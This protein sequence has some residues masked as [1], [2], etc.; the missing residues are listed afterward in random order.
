MADVAIILGG[1]ESV[2]DE[3]TA[4]VHM[5]CDA[6]LTFENFC[7]N[8][9]IGAFRLEIDHAVTLHPEMVSKW[10]LDRLNAGQMPPIKRMW[11]PKPFPGSTDHCFDRWEGSVGLF[12]VKIARILGYTK[13]VLCGV[14]MTPVNHF[15]RQKPWRE[16]TQFR[17]GWNRYKSSLAPYV[18]SNSG[19]TEELFGTPTLEWLKSPIE[20]RHPIR[21][22]FGLRA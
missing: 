15:L 19:W 1:A 14:P 10:L 12:A 16:A 6:G 11:A 8:S 13:V 3:F 2:L 22:E 17:R 4:S 7:C 20:D 9:M 18:R 21:N 5:V